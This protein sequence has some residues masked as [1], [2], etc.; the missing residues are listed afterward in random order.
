MKLI[1]DSGST[2]TDWCLTDGNRIVQCIQSPGIN[3]CLQSESEICYNIR[4][5]V[6]P[7]IHDNIDDICFY[8][9]GVRQDKEDL[10]CTILRSLFTQANKVEAHS[11]LLGAA[12]AL[13][14]R[15]EG[16]AC[17]LGT[18]ANSCLYDGRNI[19][20][21]TPALGYILGDEGSGA[22]LGRRFLNAIYKGILPENIKLE[23]EKEYK[24]SLADIINKVYRE[25][26][27]NRFLASLSPFIHRY[28]EEH[29]VRNLIIENFRDF[30]RKNIAPYKRTLQLNVLGS[31]A[32]HYADEFR[33][34]AIMEGYTVGK[35]LKGPFD[36]ADFITF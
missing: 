15:N 5:N 8:G 24:L 14:G 4:M 35:V 25:P 13:C 27:A 11:D 23:F 10:M 1:A 31:I 2:K 26:M 30:L 22:V 34:A 19:I 6:L 12:R 16:I 28:R 7:Q 17:I 33:M 18:G 36:G 21:N 9:S 32:F 29:E 3:P 20:A